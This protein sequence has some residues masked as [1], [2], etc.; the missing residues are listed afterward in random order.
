MEAYLRSASAV[1]VYECLKGW[2]TAKLNLSA[3]PLPTK[4]DSFTELTCLLP[5][6]APYNSVILM[7]THLL[8]FIL[9]ANIPAPLRVHST[10]ATNHNSCYL[11]AKPQA[12][13][14]PSTPSGPSSFQRLRRPIL[15]GSDEQS[16]LLRNGLLRIKTL[17][18]VPQLPR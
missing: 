10:S 6:S 14:M 15:P 3:R 2:T 5:Q 13:R 7:A 9:F 16:R 12:S 4:H 1:P 17:V 18:C 11:L 8:Y